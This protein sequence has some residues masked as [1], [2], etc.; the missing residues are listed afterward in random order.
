MKR[1]VDAIT[2]NQQPHPRYNMKANSL[3]GRTILA[4]AMVLPAPL[5]KAEDIEATLRFRGV[6]VNQPSR[7]VLKG[8]LRGSGEYDPID[9]TSTIRATVRTLPGRA[10]LPTV[11]GEYPTLLQFR[12]RRGDE[13]ETD[14]FRATADLRRR[15]I[16]FYGYGRIT[17]NRPVNPTRPGRQILRGKGR[18]EFDE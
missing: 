4:S 14:N 6:V 12:A 17:L 13:I 10:V 7:Q 11:L 8:R 5:S 1:S 2:P 18:F 9:D 3:L 15:A 16:V